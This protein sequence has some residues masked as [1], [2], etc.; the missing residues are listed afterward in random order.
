[1]SHKRTDIR[2]AL[3]QILTGSTDAGNRV[4]SNR[5]TPW[6]SSKLPAIN[7]VTGSEEA[8]PRDIR[9]ST[10]IRKVT[11]NIEIHSTVDSDVDDALDDLA[12]DVE[13][14]IDADRTLMGTANAGSIYKGTEI[15]IDDTGGEKP[16]GKAI[17]TYE[18]QYIFN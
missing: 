8:T 1:M 7:V 6:A 3:V 17:L 14:A 2:K 15:L 13:A 5:T 12:A 4:Y 9:A 16:I 11:F 18:I 10:Y